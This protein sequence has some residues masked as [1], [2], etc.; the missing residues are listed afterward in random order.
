[1]YNRSWSQQSIVDIVEFLSICSQR[2]LSN[3]I[4]NRPGEVHKHDN[5][6]QHGKLRKTMPLHRSPKHG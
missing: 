2:G 6:K 1:M 4:P 5:V 3:R